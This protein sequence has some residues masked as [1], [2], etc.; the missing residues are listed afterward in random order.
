MAI[1][2]PDRTRMVGVLPARHAGPI[3][4]GKIPEDGTQVL[5]NAGATNNT[6][7][8][9]TVPAGDIFYLVSWNLSV[10]VV[11]TGYVYLAVRNAGAAIQYVCELIKC[12][13]ATT[14]PGRSGMVLPPIELPAG[15]DIAVLSS[16]VGLTADASIFGY[17]I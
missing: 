14:I 2:E 17:V 5:Q 13:A 16:A 15:W 6:V 12:E 10:T 3:P 1:I 4:V 8:V 11:A 7:A 9:Y